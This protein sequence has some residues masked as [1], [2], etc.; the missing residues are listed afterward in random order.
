MDT[1]RRMK[2]VLDGLAVDFR[3]FTMERFIARLEKRAERKIFLFAGP[4]PAG[5]DGAW[6][7]DAELPHEYI[8]FDEAAVPLRQQHIQLHE[9]SHFLCGHPTLSITGDNLNA[10]LFALH[11]GRIPDV[12]FKPA[13]L[14]TQGKKDGWEEEA[15]TLALLIG[16]KVC[17]RGG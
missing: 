5:I 3:S 4:M 12:L 14:R 15:E 2:A 9:L 8:F 11:T 13:R 16:S 10:I 6:F 7:S 1:T 17:R